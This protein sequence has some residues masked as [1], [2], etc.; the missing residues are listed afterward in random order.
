M[1]VLPR[2]GR[3]S[4]LCR[5]STRTACYSTS[6]VSEDTELRT[7]PGVSQHHSLPRTTADARH[8]TGQAGAHPLPRCTNPASCIH[9]IIEH[10]RGENRR[11]FV[12]V[13][14]NK[15][16]VRAKL[17]ASNK[18]LHKSAHGTSDQK[19]SKSKPRSVTPTRDCRRARTRSR[20]YEVRITH[21]RTYEE[22]TK[23]ARTYEPP[24]KA[25]SALCTSSS[26]DHIH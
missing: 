3:T 1:Q 15:K 18:K 6:D 16:Q 19:L 20:T 13:P 25:P 10:Y 26:G 2:A 22:S 23:R 5:A 9:R 11:K 7:I 21:V 17:T 24:K 8:A 4:T 12:K 14:S